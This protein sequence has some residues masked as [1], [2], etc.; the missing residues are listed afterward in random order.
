MVGRERVAGL[1]V[2]P[3]NA[4]MGRCY[5]RNRGVGGNQV[6]IVQGDVKQIGRYWVNFV[7]RAIPTKPPFPA[8]SVFNIYK[9]SVEVSAVPLIL[10][11]F[12]ID[13][14]KTQLVVV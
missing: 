10:I 4:C 9:H 11:K 13:F 12:T 2:R 8:A 3:S 7:I 5:V 1:Y 14:N 6:V